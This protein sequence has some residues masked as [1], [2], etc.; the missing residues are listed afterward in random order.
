MIEI[1]AFSVIML[2]VFTGVIVLGVICAYEEAKDIIKEYRE[3]DKI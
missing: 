1:N 3:N 2:G